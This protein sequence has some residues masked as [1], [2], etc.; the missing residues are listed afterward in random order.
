M[1]LKSE[2]AQRE[3]DR[4]YKRMKRAGIP[5]TPI[6]LEKDINNTGVMY[7]RIVKLEKQI[8]ELQEQVMSLKHEQYTTD[9]ENSLKDKQ[10]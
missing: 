2:A 5:G 10:G 3:Y 6:T 7:E 8:A 1:P 4:I 9:L